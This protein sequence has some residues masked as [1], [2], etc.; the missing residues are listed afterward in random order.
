MGSLVGWT[1]RCTITAVEAPGQATPDAVGPQVEARVLLVIKSLGRGG[2]ERLLVSLA[3]VG[4]RSA[5]AYEIAHVLDAEDSFVDD[6]EAAGT[7]VHRLGA[8]SN[9]DLRW[10][11]T[12]RDLLIEGDFDIVH[13]HLP[14]TAALGRLV[15]AS[16]PRRRRPVT[17]Y[18]EHSLWNRTSVLV[19]L[20]NRASVG[21]DGALIAVSQAAYEALPASLQP[22]A[23]VV[24]HGVDTSATHEVLE[25]R[26]EIRQSVRAELEVPPDDL[27]VVTVANL[28]S[29]KGYDVLLDTAH[30][31]GVRGLP[32]RFAAAGDGS[33]KE[34]L[35]ACHR[36]LG[37]GERFRFLGRRHD[38]LDLLA[39]ADIVVL[40]SHWEGLPVV[41]ME[42]TGV[43]A[44]IVATSVGGV[45][46]VVQDGVNGLLVPPGRPDA[47]ADAI[48]RL[49]HDP[50]LRRRLGSQAALGSTAFDIRRASR[51]IEG[52]YRQLMHQRTDPPPVGGASPTR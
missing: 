3:T 27:L 34:E 6:A 15:V 36:A 33:L 19:K 31:V 2:A 18:T 41:L 37:L 24:V 46:Q 8:T 4:D 1:Q 40:P 28:R 20:L 17:L 21:R 9:F 7:N 16:I 39:A 38:A 13:F 23:R 26:D 22:R 52:V 50:G 48:E 25:R 43:G 45:P 32:V 30:L 44:T 42:A 14:Y 51:E 29:E 47:L 12:F 11:A 49:V 35:D 10:L 5:F